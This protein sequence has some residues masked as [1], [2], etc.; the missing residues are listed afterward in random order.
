M[1]QQRSEIDQAR[2]LV[3]RR[4]LNGCNLVSTKVL[5][6]NIEAI[7][8]RCVA[9]GFGFFARKRRANSRSEGFFGVDKLCLSFG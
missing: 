7:G 6:D 1:R 9:E 3:N 5:A 2:L 4:S 8:Q